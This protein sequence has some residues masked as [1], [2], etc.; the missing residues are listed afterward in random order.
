M[1]TQPCSKHGVSGVSRVV[2]FVHKDKAYPGLHNAIKDEALWDEVQAVLA[3]NRI[4][5][6]ARSKAADPSLLAGWV[7]DEAGERM[8][9][10]HAN[11]TRRGVGGAAAPNKTVT[12]YRYYVSQSLIKRGRPRAEAAAC[13]VPAADLKTRVEDRICALLRDSSRIN[14][15][16]GDDTVAERKAAVANA[17][18]L[19]LRWCSLPASGR[20]AILQ[21]LITRIEVRARSVHLT[22]RLSALPAMTNPDLEIASWASDNSDNGGPTE[23]LVGPAHRKADRSLLRLIGQ[24]HRCRWLLDKSAPELK[25]AEI[26]AVA[27]LALQRHHRG[28]SPQDETHPAPRLRLPLFREL[29]TP[30]QSTGCLIKSER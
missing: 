14:E 25:M 9:P 17:N 27:L 16:A 10:T 5:R 2:Q 21:V 7:F 8:S 23:T 3:E 19:A 6:V 22:V 12:R 20:R 18:K 11:K 1:R 15:S 24:E 26:A 28:L 30:R 29:P 4:E 13:R